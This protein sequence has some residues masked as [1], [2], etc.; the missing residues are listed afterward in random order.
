MYT[1]GGEVRRG[2]KG[3]CVL[4]GLGVDVPADEP[5]APGAIQSSFPHSC[6]SG[7]RMHVS[8]I[9]VGGAQSTHSDVATLR[10]S[11]AGC[12]AKPCVH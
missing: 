12:V 3:R 8:W 9:L 7:N 1:F 5:A 4:V 6:R 11:D 2:G 10:V